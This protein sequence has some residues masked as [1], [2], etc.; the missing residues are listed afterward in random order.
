MGLS[1]TWPEMQSSGESSGAV[2][3]ELGGTTMQEVQSPGELAR[4]GC[5]CG[6]GRPWGRRP[7]R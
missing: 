4:G 3:G 1:P 2:I 7:S 5:R 6:G